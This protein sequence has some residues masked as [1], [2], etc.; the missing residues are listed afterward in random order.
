MVNRFICR[1]TLSY[2]LIMK[3][4]PSHTDNIAM[5]TND[6]IVNKSSLFSQMGKLHRMQ[7]QS[8]TKL[9]WYFL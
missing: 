9:F 2:T 6:V 4:I 5:C 3:I 1:A 8:I 7:K